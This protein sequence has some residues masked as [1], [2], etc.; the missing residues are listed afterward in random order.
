MFPR[1]YAQS[2]CHALQYQTNSSYGNQHPS[3]LVFCVCASLLIITLEIT[4][5]QKQDKITCKLASR[6]P[7]S[8]YAIATKNPGPAYE[9]KVAQDHA[10]PSRS[11]TGLISP[12]VLYRA[13]L[14]GTD[15]HDFVL[16]VSVEVVDVDALLSM[17]HVLC[18]LLWVSSIK[19]LPLILLYS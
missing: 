5:I 19:S 14:T 17:L 3:Q 12:I 10:S 15:D 2:C 11:W 13:N 16:P 4:T 7:G 1:Y 18:S 9:K 8:R 6:F